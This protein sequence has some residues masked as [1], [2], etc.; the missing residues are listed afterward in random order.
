MDTMLTYKVEESEAMTCK[1]NSE[2]I[3]C[4]TSS[5]SFSDVIRP[6]MTAHGRVLC[7][8]LS[9]PNIVRILNR[10]GKHTKLTLSHAVRHLESTAAIPTEPSL[11]LATGARSL[12]ILSPTTTATGD[13][14]ATVVETTFEEDVVASSAGPAGTVY[15]V[16]QHHIFQARLEGSTVTKSNFCDLAPK[17]VVKYPVLDY[18][19]S[20]KVLLAPS[21]NSQLD[22]LSAP[23]RKSVLAGPWEPHVEATPTFARF[24]QLRPFAHKTSRLLLLTAAKGNRELRLWAFDDNK[25]KCELRQELILQ[26]TAADNE[27]FE[28]SVD[29]SEEYVILASRRAGYAV[30]VQIDCDTFKVHRVTTWRTKGPALCA[31]SYVARASSTRTS[32][33]EYAVYLHVRT[34][35]VISQC[36][37]DNNKLSGASNTTSMNKDSLVSKYFPG[38]AASATKLGT[39][40]LATV[41]S[42]GGEN[43]RS[44]TI[45]EI[46]AAGTI[47]SQTQ[48]F[49]VQLGV[50]RE[51]LKTV[52]SQA[53]GVTRMLR[54][55]RH[56]DRAQ[57]AGRDFAKR[58]LGRLH[59][60]SGGGSGGGLDYATEE[61]QMTESQ[62]ELILGIQQVVGQVQPT[63]D[64]T[65][66]ELV[67][68][69]LQQQLKAAIVKVVAGI[70]LDTT[71][72]ALQDIGSSAAGQQYQ[73]AIAAST[74]AVLA[75]LKETESRN[76]DAAASAET[77]RL[78]QLAKQHDSRL[79]AALSN[80]RADLA[81][82]RAALSL[83]HTDG[84]IV[85]D[86]DV[87]VA[88]AVSKASGGDWP[89]AF[90]LLLECSDIS[91]LLTFLENDVCS[92]QV[93][94]MTAPT[95]LP[96]HVFLS[97]CLQLT[98]ELDAH[99]GLVPLRINFFHLFF[100]EW[101]DHLKAI[102]KQ[103][104]RD[105][106][107]ASAFATIKT[108]ITVAYRALEGLDTATLDRKSRN[109]LRLV[110]RL[111]NNLLVDEE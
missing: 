87:V 42:R 32:A 35:D 40:P 1:E 39:A 2:A 107:Q 102:K 84:P 105:T 11:F 56:R 106:R 51:Q 103:A 82:T 111:M 63:S 9:E 72:G 64:A 16:G 34:A 7:T 61:G 109:N 99:P 58:N 50:L 62:R 41:S 65:S 96:L 101:D 37:L 28:I 74:R 88:N 67:K 83:L 19:H 23:T 45:P 10:K 77:E 25:K 26:P 68:R 4:K 57:E 70:Q 91:V 81:D 95:T 18:H 5:A 90:T 14:S 27:E 12:S 24:F 75:V 38:E 94:T 31:V 98:H 76:Q 80:A 85:V 29:G 110:T 22:L 59:R 79:R 13:L 52:C 8:T 73:H 54:E 44:N 92:T 21:K 20:E 6:V 97:L 60:G 43:Q 30:V 15:V 93:K 69:L 47:A 17:T 55:G 78:L 49:C 46:N 89:G 71:G 3:L 66:A 48:K 53:S 104:V 108:E 33:V 86:P 36:V 100:V